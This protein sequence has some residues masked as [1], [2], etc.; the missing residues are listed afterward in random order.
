M[1]YRVIEVS[2]GKIIDENYDDDMLQ[3]YYE[4]EL[5][6]GD[7]RIEEVVVCRNCQK[8]AEARYDWYG[9]FTGNYCDI[10]YETKYPYRK[11]RYETQ[12][13][14]GCGERLG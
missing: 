3:Y 8:D 4:T 7:Y 6:D 13:Y 10:C 9:I 2:T 14:D 12:E 11:D 5:C 1:K